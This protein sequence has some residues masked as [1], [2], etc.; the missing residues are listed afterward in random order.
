MQMLAVDK[1][2]NRMPRC[3][4]IEYKILALLIFSDFYSVGGSVRVKEDIEHTNFII[5]KCLNIM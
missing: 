3:Q 4:D 1:L 5:K 2:S